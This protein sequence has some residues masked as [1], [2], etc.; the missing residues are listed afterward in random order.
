MNKL[1][2]ISE[3]AKRLSLHPDTIRKWESLGYISSIKTIGGHR[4]Y[5]ESDV[6]HLK[7]QMKFP[8]KE[9]FSSP[10]SEISNAW[11]RRDKFLYWKRFVEANRHNPEVAGKPDEIYKRQG[12]EMALLALDKLKDEEWASLDKID[13]TLKPVYDWYRQNHEYFWESSCVG[14]NPPPMNPE[15]ERIAYMLDGIHHTLWGITGIAPHGEKN[16]L[17]GNGSFPHEREAQQGVA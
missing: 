11:Y 5:M 9:A 13:E 2:T 3:L 14:K 1:L 15:R 4:R 6:E 16:V 12:A 10:F 8:V 7:H 17:K